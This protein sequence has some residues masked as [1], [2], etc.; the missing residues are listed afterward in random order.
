MSRLYKSE[1]LSASAGLQVVRERERRLIPLGCSGRQRD[2]DLLETRTSRNLMELNK[3][4]C[5]VLLPRGKNHP[6][7]DM[8]GTDWLE[9]R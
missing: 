4:T 7:Q 1:P 3:G 9:S 2:G 6:H 8:M 5:W